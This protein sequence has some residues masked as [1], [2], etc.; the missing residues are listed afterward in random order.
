LQAARDGKVRLQQ[1][2]TRKDR[3][4]AELKKLKLEDDQKAKEMT[5]AIQEMQEKTIEEMKSK[6]AAQEKKIEEKESKN[7]AQDKT[8][9]D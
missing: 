6:N 3:A 5:G 9:N 8:T 7:A 2:D 4:F 1:E